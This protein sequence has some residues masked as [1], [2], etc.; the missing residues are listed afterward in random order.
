LPAKISEK[1]VSFSDFPTYI[2]QREL[3]DMMVDADLIQPKRE[4]LET[5][6]RAHWV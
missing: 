3:D 2:V 4:W 1:L 5:P 6:E